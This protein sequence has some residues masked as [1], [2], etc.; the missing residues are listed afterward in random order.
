M[1]ATE[2]SPLD[3]IAL[4]CELHGNERRQTEPPLRVRVAGG[5]SAYAAALLDAPAPAPD[6]RAGRRLSQLHS[7]GSKL[8]VREV[9]A[10]S[11]TRQPPL[12]RSALTYIF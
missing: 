5:P 2:L 12:R 3:A 4:A 10:R 7:I 6:R 1:Q 9:P 8:T 11:N